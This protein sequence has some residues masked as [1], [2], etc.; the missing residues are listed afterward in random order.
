MPCVRRKVEGGEIG[1]VANK[2]KEKKM[3]EVEMLK[4]IELAL[5]VMPGEC[6]C[7]GMEYQCNRCLVNS[8]LLDCASYITARA[9]TLNYSRTVDE[10]A[11]YPG[12]NRGLVGL[13]YCILGLAGEAGE[14]ANA[15]QHELRDNA[16]V[17]EALNAID[18]AALG[19]DTDALAEELGDVQFYLTR[20]AA[21]AGYPDIRQILAMNMVKVK[22]KRKKILKERKRREKD[23]KKA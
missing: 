2:G 4:R 7:Q 20:T 10:A 3:K 16:A 8:V 17:V 9:S 11:I 14:V 13:L 19:M 23:G 5:N 21:E 6:S 12:K 18:T 1:A 22:E 15:M